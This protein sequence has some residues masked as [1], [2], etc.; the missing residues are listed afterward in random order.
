M[1]HVLTFMVAFLLWGSLPAQNY[2]LGVYTGLSFYEGELAPNEFLTYVET[3]RPAFGFF[4]RAH[5][6][7]YTAVRFGYNRLK[8]MGDDEIKGVSGLDR[9]FET[10]INELY[11][12]LEIT[13]FYLSLFNGGMDVA[14]F[15]YGGGAFFSFNPTRTWNGQTVELQPLGT[16]AQGQP[17]YPD[18]YDLQNFAIIGGAGVKW[19]LNTEWT[20]SAEFGFR[21][22]FTD[23]LDD[24]SS[25]LVTY[26]D[27]LKNGDRAAAIS[28]PDFNPDS[29]DPGREYRRGGAREDW[30]M[31]GGLTL[32]Y[33]FGYSGTSSRGGRGNKMKCYE[34]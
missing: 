19:V 22:T 6:N 25:N 10:H 30:Y 9:N 15:L 34:F 3:L 32:S 29:T 11:A 4:A 5:M 7:R 1:K 16:E 31:T 14:P 2:E 21:K 18:P 17:G 26:G 13:P 28:A 24:L 20:L 23:H 33:F 12:T 8:V 27:V